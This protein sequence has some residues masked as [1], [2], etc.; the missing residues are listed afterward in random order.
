MSKFADRAR[1]TTTTTG[2]GTISLGGVFNADYVTFVQGIGTGN[3]CF[4]VIAGRGT[5]EW[6]T[7]VGTVTDLAT[8]TLSRDTVLSN[9]LGTT[10]K[11]NFSAGTKD[12]CVDMPA[13]VAISD[14]SGVL[15]AAQHPALTG[16]VTSVQ[17]ALA[18]TLDK[19]MSPTWTG[20]HTFSPTLRASGSAPYLNLNTPADT[21]LTA[22]V[23]AIGIKIT[24]ATR[25]HAQGALTTQREISITS[26]TYSFATSSSTITQ[27]CTLAI[28]SYPVLG[29]NAAATSL[30]GI[31]VGNTTDGMAIPNQVSPFKGGIATGKDYGTDNSAGNIFQLSSWVNNA[32][33]AQSVAV[34]GGGKGLGTNSSVYGGN[35]V[36]YL[37]TASAT[38]FAKGLEV[39]M[40]RLQA[41]TGQT[42]GILI[43]AYGTHGNTAHLW[44]QS[45]LSG[46]EPDNCVVFSKTAGLQPVKAGGALIT[47]SGTPSVGTGIDFATGSPV[48]TIAP[49][50]FGNNSFPRALNASAAQIIVGGV[51][52]HNWQL[53]QSGGSGVRWLNAANTLNI[54]RVLDDG[55][56]VYG[57]N[58]SAQITSNQNNYSPTDGS[59]PNA[60]FYQ[61]WSSDASR[62]V[63][64]LTFPEDPLGINLQISGQT[65]M[66]VNVGSQAIVLINESGLSTAANRFTTTTGADLTLGA[67]R[68]AR[69][70]YDGTT[71][72]WRV[73]LLP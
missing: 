14:F 44:M 45:A 11:I 8:D 9:S 19:T 6:E 36:G 47:T 64:G 65:L 17:G 70:F 52:T 28:D 37:D 38:A 48:F 16:D 60:S 31:W 39:D 53:F 22:S 62:N 20:I 33:S 67:N 27:A 68:M 30:Y 58:T 23:E 50:L 35:F 26:P 40:G 4:Y 59:L 7:G 25:Q 55:G 43:A 3:T 29:T 24:G 71:S 61:R 32:G 51:D 2:T 54:F 46:A 42:L 18:T 63:T 12:C 41:G 72:R 69:A 15:A 21:T 1:E 34:F 56:M 5:G 66:I 57:M 49:I 13:G 73:T 10:A